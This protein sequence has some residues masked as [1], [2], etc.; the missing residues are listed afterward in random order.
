MCYERRKNCLSP[1]KHCNF[2]LRSKILTLQIL[3]RNVGIAVS[4][5]KVIHSFHRVIH[6]CMR[7]GAFCC[8]K[9]CGQL[10]VYQQSIGGLAMSQAKCVNPVKKK[11]DPNLSRHG[12]VFLFGISF[13]KQCGNMIIT[14]NDDLRMKS[15]ICFA[16]SI[17]VLVLLA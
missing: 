16:N 15:K 7:N 9:R 3:C 17:A 2:A 1:K 5:I 10:V 13:P 11:H 4:S 12:A 14:M 6:F 8:E